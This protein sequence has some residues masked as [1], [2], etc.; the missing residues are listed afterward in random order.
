MKSKS[1]TITLT[2][3]EH[4]LLEASLLRFSLAT[5]ELYYMLAF[6]PESWTEESFQQLRNKIAAAKPDD[7]DAE[8]LEAYH[9]QYRNPRGRRG[10]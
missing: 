5:D 10:N 3:Q 1:V 2:E 7:S 8:D 4:E 6:S 9:K